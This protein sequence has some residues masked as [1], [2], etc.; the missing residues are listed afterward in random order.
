MAKNYA[1]IENDTVT[2]V[3]VADSVTIAKKVTGKECIECDGSFWIGWTRTDEEWIA[4][5]V[6]EVIETVVDEA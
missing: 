1:V 5:V 4:P 2:N 3:I 6:P